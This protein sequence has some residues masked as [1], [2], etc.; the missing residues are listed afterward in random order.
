MKLKLASTVLLLLSLHAS[1]PAADFSLKEESGKHLDVLSDGKIIARY[2]TAHDKSTPER[3]LE[4][5]KPYLHIFDAQGTDPITKGAG[6]DFTHH[7]GIF[8]GWNKIGV[9]GKTYDRW[10]MKGGDQVH[11][12]FLETKADAEGATVTSLVKWDGEPGGGP[13]LQDE[14]TFHFLPAKAP[15]HVVVDVTHKVKALAGDTTLSGDPEHAGLHYR[16][17]QEVDRSKTMYIYPVENANAH[18]DQDYP[19]VGESYVV[20]GKTYHVIYLNHLDN[21]KKARASAYRDYG[22]FGMFFDTSLKKDEVLTLK[23]RF[24]IGEGPLPN[25][26]AIQKAWNEFNGGRNDPTPQDTL[27]PAEGATKTPGGK[28][29]TKP[30]TPAEPKVSAT[31]PADSAKAT[32]EKK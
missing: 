5:Y 28:P 25:A 9:N 19:W 1:M 31:K 14:R 11:E 12:K 17:A 8:L 26:E 15:N 3:A 7:R 10:H 16:P 20:G 18:K 24:L 32:P 2:M 27:K 30:K 29:K 4:T 22:R 13:I 6:G 23:V 21:P